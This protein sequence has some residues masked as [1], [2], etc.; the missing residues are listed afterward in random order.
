MNKKVL[1]IVFIVVLI[2]G[3]ITAAV[4]SKNLS[5]KNAQ[6]TS[7]SDE[8]ETTTLPPE[9]RMQYPDRL[10]GVLA[11]DVEAKDD[12]VIITYGDSGTVKRVFVSEELLEPKT[13]YTETTTAET[14]DFTVTYSGKDGKIYTAA[15]LD[16]YNSYL[17]ELNPDGDGIDEEEMAQYIDAT[18]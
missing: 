6:T 2:V 16:N 12:T 7:V 13:E 15:W 11:T 17:I 5:D 18:E 1:A 4:I 8:T 9:L 10:C 3:V 14:D